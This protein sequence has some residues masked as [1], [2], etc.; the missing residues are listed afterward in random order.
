MKLVLIFSAI[1]LGAVATFFVFVLIR[2]SKGPGSYPYVS[3]GTLLTKS[4][5]RFYSVF[6]KV[7]PDGY[8]ICPKVRMEDIIQVKGG[9]A[10]KDRMS[11]RGRIKSRHLDFV[12]CS[13]SDARIFFCIEL[14]D[15]SHNRS[16]RQER[17]IFVNKAM[18]DAGVPLLRVLTS[19]S[20]SKDSMA[21]LFQRGLDSQVF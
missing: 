9:L 13:T 19:R 16:D 17:D 7:L 21:S 8:M 12:V 4:E 2:I 11:W 20:Y 18:Q 1:I 15:S 10:N 3:S 5:L 14:D 6:R